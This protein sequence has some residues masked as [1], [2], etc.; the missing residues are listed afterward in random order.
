[1]RA[2]GDN[3][4]GQTR[5]ASWLL[6][7]LSK[8]KDN[9]RVGWVESARPTLHPSVS[10]GVMVYERDCRVSAGGGSSEKP[11]SMFGPPAVRE[12][13]NAPLLSAAASSGNVLRERILSRG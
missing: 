4:T 8:G 11:T 12:R 10:S 5:S 9:H 2:Q 1:M 3:R 13:A 6:T 7:F